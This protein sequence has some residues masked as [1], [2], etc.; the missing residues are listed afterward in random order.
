MKIFSTL[1]PALSKTPHPQE[2]YFSVSK[3][4]PIFVVADGVTLNLNN[5][6]D[7][8][9]K[10]GAGD[11]AKIFCETVISAA[12]NKYEDFE[13]ESASRRIKEIFEAGNK[14]VAEYNNSQVLTKDKINYWDKDLFSATTSFLLIKDKKMYW[15]SLCDSGVKLF[16]SK[17]KQ[18]FFSPGCWDICRKFLPENWTSMKE[19]EKIIMLHRD[20][21]N[22]IGEDGRLI[23]YGVVTGEESAALYFNAGTIDLKK[24]DLVFVY[25]DGFENYF[26]LKEFI[27]IF[28]LWPNNLEIKLGAFVFKKSKEEPAKYGSEKTLIAIKN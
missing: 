22:K 17:G 4:Y 5:N 18:S 2:D 15:F 19:K 25:T 11:V 24:G 28:K 20:F 14:A 21:R 8:P 16:D 13:E 7:Y 23:G 26:D 10:S 3:K 9:E 27:N 1:K 6:E 12:E